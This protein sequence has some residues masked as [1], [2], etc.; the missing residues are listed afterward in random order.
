MSDMFESAGNAPDMNETISFLDRAFRRKLNL[1]DDWET[2][3][4]EIIGNT[5]EDRAIGDMMVQGGVPAVIKT[6]KRKG[7]KTWKGVAV[8]KCIITDREIADER[9]MYERETGKCSTCYGTG[10]SWF[11]W[12]KDAG[13]RYHDCKKCE[14][15]GK[16]KIIAEA[17]E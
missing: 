7:G 11:E 6:G 17:A 3:S 10:Q 8:R 12:S 1:S 16:T 5:Q 15:T 9:R 4:W 13:N 2:F 14:A